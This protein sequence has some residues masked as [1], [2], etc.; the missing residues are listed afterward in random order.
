[1]D[2][3]VIGRIFFVM[4]IIAM[5]QVVELPFVQEQIPPQQLAQPQ[6]RL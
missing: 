1:M 2:L 3:D 4:V 6:A 5:E